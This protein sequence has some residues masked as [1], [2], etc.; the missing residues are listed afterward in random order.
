[1]FIEQQKMLLGSLATFAQAVGKALESEM[2]PEEKKGGSLVRTAGYVKEKGLY[3]PEFYF[4]RNV[5]GIAQ[6]KIVGRTESNP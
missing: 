5:H 3:H 6:L 2:L 1:M 4:V